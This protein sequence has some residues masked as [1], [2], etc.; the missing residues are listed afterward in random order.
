MISKYNKI[1]IKGI[2][3]GAVVVFIIGGFGIAI[4]TSS[5]SSDKNIAEAITSQ[6]DSPG[7]TPKSPVN[8]TSAAS[9]NIKKT[10]SDNSN[11]IVPF[12]ADIV[13]YNSHPDEVYPSGMKVT[14]VGATISD[15]LVKEGFNS[16]FV[17]VEPSKDYTKS[18]QITRDM[19]TK[20]V[21]NYSNTILLDIH[22]DSAT[23]KSKSYTKR[24]GFDVT[25]KNPRY[26][27]DKRFVD[28][29]IENIKNSNGVESEIYFYQYGM[30]FYN[31]DLSNKASVI[32]IGNNLSSD[33]DIEACVNELVSALKTTQKVSAN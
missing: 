11:F 5:I 28:S 19:I 12:S 13:V 14:D 17:K 4:N 30:S 18:F 16:H 3:L 33:S 26:E 15:K 22:R 24:I 10:S 21:N 29:L 9:S 25:Q 27:S 2:L 8:N 1:N 32:E 6:V 20:N 7:T 31:E 23:V